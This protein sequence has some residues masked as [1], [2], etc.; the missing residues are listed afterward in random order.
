MLALY[1]C[2]WSSNF[3]A[4]FV[5]VGLKAEPIFVIVGLKAEPIFVIVGLKAE[6]DV[7]GFSSIRHGDNVGVGAV[8]PLQVLDVVVVKDAFGV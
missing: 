3:G 2:V 4:I 6:L 5:I 7:A 1:L 8:G